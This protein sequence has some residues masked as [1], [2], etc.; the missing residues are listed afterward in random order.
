MQNRVMLTITT[1][2][3]RQFD[4]KNL[5]QMKTVYPKAFNF[6]QEKNIPGHYDKNRKHSYHLTVECRLED[7]EEKNGKTDTSVVEKEKR[8]TKTALN[9]TTLIKRRK[10]FNR[11]L[12]DIAKE[13]HKTFLASL[14]PPLHIPDEKIL[15]WHPAFA[16]DLVPEIEAA[17]LPTPPIKETYTTAK[18]V[19]RVAQGRL[20]ERVQ[21]ALA[22]AGNS[23]EASDASDAREGKR[24]AKTEENAQVNHPELRGVSAALLEK[25]NHTW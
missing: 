20:T 11:S 17:P 7:D 24:V 21:T 13:H 25:V 23:S 6:R 15:R 3:Y 1:R 4:E 9:A 19:L 18:D 2:T 5:G 22:G 8:E 12:T 14:S 10:R 16:L